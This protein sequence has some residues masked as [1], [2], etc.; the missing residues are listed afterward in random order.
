MPQN[1]LVLEYIYTVSPSSP[2]DNAKVGITMVE[3]KHIRLAKDMYEAYGLA[4]HYKNFQGNPMPTWNDLPDGIQ[5][6]WVEAGK[7]ARLELLKEA[8]ANAMDILFKESF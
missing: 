2:D 3:D 1:K 4:T 7:K 5:N 8:M 6:A